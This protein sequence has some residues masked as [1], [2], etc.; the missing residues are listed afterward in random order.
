MFNCH[1][2]SSAFTGTDQKTG[3]ITESDR[4]GGPCMAAIADFPQLKESVSHVMAQL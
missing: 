4:T 1:Y 3:L 2:L